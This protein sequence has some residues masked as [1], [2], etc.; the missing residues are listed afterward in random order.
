M[1]SLRKNVISTVISIGLIV[2]LGCGYVLH[3]ERR[4]Q[5][6]G[7]VDPGIAI[8][9]G[10]GLLFYVVPG[11][12]AFAVDF[13]SGAIYL[14]S[15]KSD[16]NKDSDETGLLEVRE[17]LHVVSRDQEQLNRSEIKSIVETHLDRSVDL[18]RAVVLNRCRNGH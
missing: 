16:R 12:V 15:D 4:G 11:V 9:D 2:W 6:G 7:R 18:D 1:N 13:S 14:P 5:T 17:D 3:P 10:I 8:L